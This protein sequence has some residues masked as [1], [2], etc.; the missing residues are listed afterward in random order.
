M[1]PRNLQLFKFSAYGFLKNLRFFEPFLILFFREQGISFLQIGILFSVR[2]L[3]SML[4]E[5]PTGIFADSFGRRLSMIAAFVMYIISF[6]IFFFFPEYCFYFTAMVF[7][8]FGEAFRTG[9]HKALILEYLR[10]NHIEEHKVEYYGYTRSWSQ[11]GSAV[12]AL[13]A[14]L[15]VFYSGSYRY[16]FIASV[17]P[18]ILALFLMI[19]YP[20]ELDG[21]IN[22][23]SP[24]RIYS[25]LINDLR[26]TMKN[27]LAIFK[28]GKLQRIL[29]NSSLFDALFKT[30]KDYIQPILKGL[31]FSSTILFI[32]SREA[33]I[34]AFIYF[35]IYLMSSFASRNAAK[36]VKK[37]RSLPNSINFTYILGIFSILLAGIAFVLKANIITI[38]VF[39][40]LFIL[41]NLRR[42]MNVGYLSEIIPAKIM[43]SGLST[44]SQLKNLLIVL[45]AP[46]MGFLADNVGIGYGLIILSIVFLLLYNFIKLKR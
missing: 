11:I 42:P 29:F 1:I 38:I 24:G 13:L 8:A 27:F 37:L 20:R 12:S 9:T 25:D 18:Y 40:L 14:G 17:I 34:I 30:I 19:S 16:I 36:F 21:K 41:Q 43:A 44:E 23:T 45:L 22:Q 3:A 32:T 31:I 4:L 28:I 15:L 2:E 46:L 35:L 10:M 6:I 33:L 5:I 39:L 7:F 26:C